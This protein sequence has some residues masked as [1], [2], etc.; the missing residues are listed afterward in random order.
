VVSLVA[1]GKKVTVLAAAQKAGTQTV[2]VS[3]DSFVN[4]TDTAYWI[5]LTDGSRIKLFPQSRLTA[6]KKLT[7]TREI[8]LEGKAF[9]EVA[10]DKT[11]PFTVYSG[12]INT[13]ALGTSFTI[14]ALSGTS[15]VNVELFT[16]RVVVKAD[17]NRIKDVYL[18]PGQQIRIDCI[19]YQTKTIDHRLN[20]TA[21]MQEQVIEKSET[22]DS[23]EF[24]QTPLEKVFTQLQQHFGKKISYTPKDI[25]G[26]SFT[27]KIDTAADPGKILNTIAAMNGLK[28]M[29]EKDGFLIL[30]IQ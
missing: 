23:F 15:A 14:T 17:N 26:M 4:R 19:T 10:K 5:D 12:H 2:I 9:F 7:G 30:P 28:V 24:E 22:L 11:R 3:Q 27:G 18:Q 20:T 21:H 25:K 16:G 8:H 1:P 6:N 13:T 29:G